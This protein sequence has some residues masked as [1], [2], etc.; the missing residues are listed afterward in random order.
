MFIIFSK[1]CKDAV[2]IDVPEDFL[3]FAALAMVRLKKGQQSNVIYNLA[4]GVGT[5]CPDQTDSHFSVS[6]MPMG[7]VEY[8]TNFF[9]AK[10]IN[11]VAVLSAVLVIHYP[12]VIGS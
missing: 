12:W 4:R 10:D 9:V 5:E 1:Y 3:G 8:V 6:R 11:M 7:L 2:H